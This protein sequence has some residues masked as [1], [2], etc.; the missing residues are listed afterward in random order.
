MHKTKQFKYNVYSE[1]FK[2]YI[3]LINTMLIIQCNN[4]NNNIHNTHIHNT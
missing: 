2:M 3:D 1:K 4:N